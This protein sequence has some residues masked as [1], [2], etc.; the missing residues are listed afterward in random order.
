ML[1]LVKTPAVCLLI[2]LY[3]AGFYYRKP[4]IPVKSTRIFQWLI[5]V[6][7]VNSTFDYHLYGKS[8]RYRS[9]FGESDCPHHLSAVYISIRL[10]FI[11][12][13]E[14]LFGNNLKISQS[15]KNTAQ[16]ACCG[17]D[18]GNF[19]I[20]NYICSGKKHRLFLRT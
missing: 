10:S 14:K 20:A 13:H 11:Y 8:Q 16:S 17:I 2:T 12:I 1:M 5:A 4:H 15:N 9:G 18:C 3:M 19:R 7:I 6:A